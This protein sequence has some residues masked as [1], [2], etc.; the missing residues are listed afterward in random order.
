MVCSCKSSFCICNRSS[1]RRSVLVVVVMVVFVVMV[2]VAA[3]VL[4]LV[5]TAIFLHLD[6]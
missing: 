5:V 2:V 3:V 1:V 4:V 6:Y